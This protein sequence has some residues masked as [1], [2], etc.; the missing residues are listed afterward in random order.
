MKLTKSL[1]IT[2]FIIA[3]CRGEELENSRTASLDSSSQGLNLVPSLPLPNIGP[4]NGGL[5]RVVTA[6]GS[7]IP[8]MPLYG[9]MHSI[10]AIMLEDLKAGDELLV[11]G[12]AGFT[13]DVATKKATKA[14]HN[15]KGEHRYTVNTV[16]H[17]FYGPSVA[18][19]SVFS[20]KSETTSYKNH[21]GLNTLAGEITVSDPGVSVVTLAM[22]GDVKGGK[23]PEKTVN[24]G[25]GKAYPKN[26]AAALVMEEGTHK[27]QLDVIVRSPGWREHFDIVTQQTNDSH[28]VEQKVK[29]GEPEVVISFPL[30][31]VKAGE[32]IDIESL[33]N[34]KAVS[35]NRNQLATHVIGISDTAKPAKGSMTRI[36]PKHGKNI[37][38]GETGEVSFYAARAMPNYMP[39]AHLVVFAN[40][41]SKPGD[42]YL[43]VLK[44]SNVKITRYVPKSGAETS[45]GTAEVTAPAP[46]APAR[47]ALVVTAP[48]PSPSAPVETAPPPA[49]SAP[50]VT[51]PPPAPSPVMCPHFPRT[52]VNNGGDC[53]D[54]CRKQ[55]KKAARSINISNIPS[56]LSDAGVARDFYRKIRDKGKEKGCDPLRQTS[57][58]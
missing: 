33:F 35:K 55:L 46:G 26:N 9:E 58:R 57:Y 22:K 29:R 43:E 3:S 11:R 38:P 15:Y 25:K 44:G 53:G 21:H 52:P 8:Y 5:V 18:T 23:T 47:S 42:E 36:S 16:A 7:A 30:G 32:V 31:E 48:P 49:P 14:S 50:V 20:K 4:N 39:E 19:G 41:M 2:A 28:I 45:S 1:F 34:V 54:A 12:M 51:A 24:R 27:S 37:P 10:Q 56:G 40:T 6:G 13:N 17:L